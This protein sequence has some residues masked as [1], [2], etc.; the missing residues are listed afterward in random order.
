MSDKKFD[1]VVSGYTLDGFSLKEAAINLGKVFSI[2][3]EKALLLLQKKERVVRR[4]VDAETA[5]TWQRVLSK[6]GAETLF[7][8]HELAAANALPEEPS[9][10]NDGPAMVGTIRTGGEGFTGA[11]TVAAPGARMSEEP[12]PVPEVETTL[13][14]DVDLAPVGADIDTLPDGKKAVEVDISHLSFAD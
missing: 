11:F 4:A 7:V 3:P 14:K 9:Q 8:E 10:K 13:L 1:V 6:A 12:L 2:E 5:T